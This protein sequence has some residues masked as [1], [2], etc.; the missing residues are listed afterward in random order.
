MRKKTRKEFDAEFAE[1]AECA[2]KR[3]AR[4]KRRDGVQLDRKSP[5]FA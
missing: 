5:P 3:R 4:V 2:E 1:N